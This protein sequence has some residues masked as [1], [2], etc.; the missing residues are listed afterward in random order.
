MFTRLGRFKAVILN[1]CCTVESPSNLLKSIKAGAPSK[2]S[3][4][5]GLGWARVPV[6]F[7]SPPGDSDWQSQLKIAILGEQGKHLL[8]KTCTIFILLSSPKP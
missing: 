3:N 4:L 5:T 1:L 8:K 2:Y 6:Y 7:K